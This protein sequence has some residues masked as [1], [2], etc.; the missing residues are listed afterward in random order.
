MT[1]AQAEIAKLTADL[2]H[3]CEAT[4]RLNARLRQA[5]EARD[6]WKD[7]HLKDTA[8]LQNELRLREEEIARRLRVDLAPDIG[9]L[10]VYL[11]Q[12][13]KAARTRTSSVGSAVLLDY[14]AEGR[15]VGV[16]ILGL[17]GLPGSPPPEE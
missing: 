9:A 1:D 6:G 4:A 5:E 14:D 17:D 12:E 2:Q 11:A 3:Q 8:I 7:R 13:S 15:L 10:Y 16:E